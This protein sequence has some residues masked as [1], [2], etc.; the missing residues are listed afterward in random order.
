ME[1]IFENRQKHILESFEKGS[2]WEFKYKKII[3]W[4]KNLPSFDSYDKKWLVQGC[5][6]QVWLKPLKKQGNI[7]IFQGDSDALIT[8][9]LLALMIYFYSET[10]AESILKTPPEFIKKLDLA[11][12]LTPTR[13]G[14]IAALEKQ[15]KNYAQAYFLLK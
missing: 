11:S 8:K 2:N 5:Q 6:A 1:T 12:H 14:G 15:I 4:G 3:E 13:R 7:I 9:G 10:Q